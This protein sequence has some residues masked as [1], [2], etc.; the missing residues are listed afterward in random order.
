M[1]VNFLTAY[2]P[3]GET[4][5]ENNLSRISKQ[6]LNNG[7]W[8]DLIPLLPIPFLFDH[9]SDF[10][11]LAFLIKII[12]VERGFGFF[13]VGKIMDT[14][15]GKIKERI[16]QRI[17]DDPLI[18]EDKVNDHN[19]IEFIMVTGYIFATLKLVIIILNCSF[20]LGL[21]F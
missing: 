13:N 11:Q 9:D 20:F 10:H 1:A 2:T 4:E 18:G 16:E 8:K 15:K 21:M 5:P 7:F 6:Y 17:K 3:L 19:N 12:R 14:F